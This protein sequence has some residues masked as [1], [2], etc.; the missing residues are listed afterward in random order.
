MGNY[1]QQELNVA[2]F[3]FVAMSRFYFWP[4]IPEYVAIVGNK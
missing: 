4:D 1:K 3:C 2:G